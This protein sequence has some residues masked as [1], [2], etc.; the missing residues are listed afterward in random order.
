MQHVPTCVDQV[1]TVWPDWL[2]HMQ[3]A[4]TQSLKSNSCEAGLWAQD[5]AA[6]TVGSFHA[7]QHESTPALQA[8]MQ[9][10][11]PED[12]YCLVLINGVGCLPVSRLPMNLNHEGCIGTLQQC[13]KD[14][15]Q[16][17][18]IQ[19]YFDQD[20]ASNVSERM[21]LENLSGLMDGMCVCLSESLD[22]PLHVVHWVDARARGQILCLRHCLKMASSATL[23]LTHWVV[24]E[25]AVQCGLNVSFHGD[26]GVDAQCHMVRIQDM[27][28]GMLL[29]ASDDVTLAKQSVYDCFDLNLGRGQTYQRHQINLKGT[30]SRC[31]LRGVF[32]LDHQQQ[33]IYP[34]RVD[35]QAAHT[36]SNQQ[37][38]A[39]AKAEAIGAIESRVMVRPGAVQINSKQSMRGIVL[40]TGAQL[41][42]RPE[43]E[44][45]ADEVQ[46]QHGASVGAL[47]VEALRYLMARGI[48]YQ[49]ARAM[50]IQALIQGVLPDHI[51]P[52]I[53]A[54]LSQLY[55]L[56][57]NIE[58]MS[59][60]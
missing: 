54:L 39:L 13:L 8:W 21:Q 14:P 33:M 60:A 1:L 41:K 28:D 53:E 56:D 51:D 12:A 43:L 49:Q 27:P 55:Q 52:S 4:A 47:D 30:G 37:F 5:W 23:D 40:D 15:V 3:Q 26:L 7:A 31:D 58:V 6:Y 17:A 11:I 24:G 2:Q 57:Q 38:C 45:Y 35:H 36:V 42:V 29:M 34:V 10:H 44:I 48:S 25:S 19:A 46:C 18:W 16:A 50:L 59:D 9:S 20:N 22:R 32:D